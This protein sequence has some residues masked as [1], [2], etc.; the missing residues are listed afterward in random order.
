MFS[1]LLLNEINLVTKILKNHS[2]VSSL[3]YHTIG[4]TTKTGSSLFS[5]AT[6]SYFTID[7]VWLSRRDSAMLRRRP[8]LRREWSYARTTS[9]TL[10]P[11]ALYGVTKMVFLQNTFQQK[12]EKSLDFSLFSSMRTAIISVSRCRE[13]R[14]AALP[15]W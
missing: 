6:P 13:F 11:T 7:S 1:D 10:R 12:R 5:L 4:C 14:S 9:P 2:T 8:V 3:S 15:P